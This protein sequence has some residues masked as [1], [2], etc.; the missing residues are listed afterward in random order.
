MECLKSLDRQESRL[1]RRERMR[2]RKVDL[3]V[4]E[5]EK[6]VEKLFR[7]CEYPEEKNFG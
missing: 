3:C 1:C 4:C 5:K 7:V 6:S 2:E